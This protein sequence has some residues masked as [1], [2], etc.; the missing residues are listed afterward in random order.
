MGVKTL[1]D[2]FNVTAIKN[3]IGKT[4]LAKSCELVKTTLEKELIIHQAL[5]F[6]NEKIEEL[7]KENEE[8]KPKAIAY[9]TYMNT[10]D[11]MPI[12]IVATELKYGR[13]KLFKLLRDNGI[14][15]KYNIPYQRYIENGFFEVKKTKKN[16]GEIYDQTFAKNKGLELCRKL[17]GG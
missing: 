12:R 13:N 10:D 4:D 7:K 9:D 17:I 5:I 2:E 8:M 6:Q 16:N 11:I 15:D 1:L 3:Y 14:L